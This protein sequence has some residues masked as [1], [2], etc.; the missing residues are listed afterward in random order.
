MSGESPAQ[1]FFP[2][3]EADGGWYFATSP[4][5]I[6]QQAGLQPDRLALAA[7]DLEGRFGSDSWTI[8]V[9]RHGI[10]AAEIIS[11]SGSGISR[12]DVASV[13]KSFTSLA[14][15]MLFSDPQYA[16]TLNLESKAYDFIP[17]GHPLNDI[18]KKDVSVGHL[19]SMTGGFVGETYGAFGGE[20][21]FGDGIWEYVLGR[22]PSRRGVDVARLFADPGTQWEYSDPG[23]AHL[24]L[25]FAEV[26]G[27]EIDTYLNRRL[28]APIGIPPVSWA[29][30]GGGKLIGPHALSYSG[31]VI[32]ARELARCGYLLL[33]GGMWNG[34]S[35]V[36]QDWI[37]TATQPSQSF[38]RRYGYGIW[39]NT[40][41]SLWPELPTDAFAMMGY[42]GNRCWVV[43]SLDL[44]IAR[45]ATGPSELDL[46]YVPTLILN[47]VI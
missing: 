9:V 3:P 14:F 8:C 11:F 47:A 26:T 7:R 27:E 34:R 45:V 25:V 30:S 4:E 42:R 29:R 41:G 35:I 2:A 17:V 44:V 18:K 1:R 39:V 23:Y 31:L 46:R 16:T 13:T 22:V 40:T 36:S 5:E 10:L 37:R 21:R 24:A 38:N 12:F 20:T 43:P 19:L 15:G 32:S 33:C 6:R 28:F